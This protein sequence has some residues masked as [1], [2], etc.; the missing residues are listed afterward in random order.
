MGLN[1]FLC[2]ELCYVI[3][4]RVASVVWN[5]GVKCNCDEACICKRARVSI[6]YPSFVDRAVKEDGGLGRG[7]WEG[8][9]G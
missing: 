2:Y 4:W 9:V 1:R 8:L 7:N 3:A 5:C 6:S